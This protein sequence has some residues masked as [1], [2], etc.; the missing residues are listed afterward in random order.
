MM[1]LRDLAASIGARLVGVEAD[2]E[3]RIF[4]S[5]ATDSRKFKSGAL[6]VALRG[7]HFDG[8]EFVA[9]VASQG[10]A[11]AIVDGRFA[12]ERAPLPLLVVDDTRIALGKLAAAWR[13]RFS[14]PLIA[15]AGSNG[16][17]TVK[18]MIAAILRDHFGAQ[19]ILST[20]GNFNNDIGLP[21]TLLRLRQTHLAAVVEIGM[22]HPGETAILAA[23]ARP[24]IALVNNAQREHQEFMSSVA[25]VAR[26]H[27]FLP[28]S[29]PRG[30]VAVFNADDEHAAVWHEAAVRVGAICR[31]FGVNEGAEIHANCRLAQ[32][33]SDI[34]AHTPEGSVRFELPMPGLHNV[35]NALAAIGASLAAG[36][37][38]EAAARALRT[39]CAVKGRMQ[40]KLTQGGATLIDD[41]Y[42]ANPESVHA[43]IEVLAACP[44]PRVL[45]LGDMGE[46]GQQGAA[47]HTEVGEHARM[48]GL[49]ALITFGEQTR[50]T[51]TAFGRGQHAESIEQA[52]DVLRHYDRAGATLLV[53]GSRFMRMER[54]VAA[55]EPQPSLQ[56][57]TEGAH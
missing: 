41:T 16:K 1:T 50:H 53:K 7:E 57:I 35:R 6:F 20:E 51:A 55:L 17:T 46:V 45:V 15:V 22:N 31:E 14:I 5:V 37:S 44:E 13:A 19:Q 27:A 3:S 10:A 33:A 38:L 39:F 48:A 40:K 34:E 21:L 8:H 29:L 56:S 36:A 2:G 4:D 28:A 11:A 12:A 9:A 49:T 42:N 43:A 47:F 54:V 52:I 32:F 26:E 23:I 30:G 24:S 25:E 18:E